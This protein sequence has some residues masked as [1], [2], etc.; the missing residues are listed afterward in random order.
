M[1]LNGGWGQILHEHLDASVLLEIQKHVLKRLENVWLPMFLASEQFAGRQ[2]IK[3]W[4]WRGLGV[5]LSQPCLT[6]GVAVQRH[7]PQ[8]FVSKNKVR[9]GELGIEHMPR[10]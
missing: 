4:T 2:K 5:A 6:S 7:Y 8:S 3:V 10:L 9:S 1:L